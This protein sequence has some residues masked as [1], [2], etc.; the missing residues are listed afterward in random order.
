LVSV[1]SSGGKTISHGFG[2]SQEQQIAVVILAAAGFLPAQPRPES[3]QPVTGTGSKRV[4]RPSRRV[5]IMTSAELLADAF[6]RIREDV[7]GA[8]ADMSEGELAEQLD[9]GANSIAWLVWHLTRIMDDHAADAF[10]AGQVWPAWAGRFGLP[11]NVEETGY[12]QNITTVAAVRAPAELLLGY[13][14]AVQ[15]MLE[16]LIAA[17]KDEG[18][19]RIVDD[20]WDPPVTLGVRLI[21]VVNDATQHAGQAAFVRGALLRRR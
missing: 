11:F 8:V 6:G 13:H 21:S 9:P 5:V 10:G 14:N 4:D 17:V 16:P 20:R 15:D 3:P 19:D 7:H 18:L 12:G 2:I 1:D